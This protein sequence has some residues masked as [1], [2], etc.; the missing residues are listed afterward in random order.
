MQLKVEYS[1]A[2][3]GAGSQVVLRALEFVQTQLGGSGCLCCP[4][5][6]QKII[7]HQLWTRNQP[8]QAP[9]APLWL[10]FEVTLSL[11]LVS[12]RHAI[13]G[14]WCSSLEASTLHLHLAWL[15][16]YPSKL[17]GVTLPRPPLHKTKRKV[18]GYTRLRAQ[19]TTPTLFEFIFRLSCLPLNSRPP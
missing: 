10:F 17:G 16:R 18:S 3:E 19:Q 9:A 15:P 12:E 14:L 6:Y 13:A 4:H 7:S 8:I 1:R 11:E 5:S 2:L